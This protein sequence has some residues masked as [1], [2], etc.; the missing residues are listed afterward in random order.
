[1]LNA[2]TNAKNFTLLLFAIANIHSKHPPPIYIRVSTNPDSIPYDISFDE[3]YEAFLEK[4]K[5]N[6]ENSIPIAEYCVTQE[7]KNS[8]Y[9]PWGDDDG[10]DSAGFYLRLE[11]ILQEQPGIT[12]CGADC[13]EKY[14]SDFYWRSKFLI[15]NDLRAERGKE[16]FYGL[17]GGFLGS[18]HGSKS[19]CFRTALWYFAG[20]VPIY[21]K[22]ATSVDFSKYYEKGKIIPVEWQ[23]YAK[24]NSS[25]TTF[26]G[27]YNIRIIGKCS[28]KELEK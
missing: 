21:A 11:N 28:E 13:S 2:L 12:I 15:S 20:E 8:N 3:E 7:K 14:D 24:C 5:A 17:G 19:Y 27:S 23:L 4:T 18:S 1:M 22:N 25:E 16:C 9:C 6:L 26:S 10:Y